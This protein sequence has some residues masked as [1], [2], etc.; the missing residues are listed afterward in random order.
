MVTKPILYGLFLALMDVF[1][2]GIIKNVDLGRYS[3][4]PAMII[5]TIFYSLAPWIFLKSLS[6]SSLTVMNLMWDLMSD[7]LVTAVGLFYFKE[8]VSNKKLFGIIFAFLGIFLLSY[9]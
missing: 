7:I 4:I 1:N 6:G 9:D 8:E 2:L 5:P 3:M